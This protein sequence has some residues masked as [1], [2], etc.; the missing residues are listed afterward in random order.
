MSSTFIEAPT[1]ADLAL[2]AAPSA[3]LD[4]EHERRARRHRAIYELRELT[5]IS[6]EELNLMPHSLLAALEAQGANPAACVLQYYAPRWRGAPLD[7]LSRTYCVEGLA[8]PGDSWRMVRALLHLDE[9]TFDA[10]FREKLVS[11]QF[12]AEQHAAKA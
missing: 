2:A 8:V 11:A 7:V 5:G 3:G 10:L 6:P 4:E 9:V 1:A 12:T